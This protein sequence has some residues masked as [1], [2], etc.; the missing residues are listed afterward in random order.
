MP[1]EDMKTYRL[2]GIKLV[3]GDA[4]EHNTAPG[5]ADDSDSMHELSLRMAALRALV[6]DLLKSNQELRLALGRAKASTRQDTMHDKA[7][8]PNCPVLP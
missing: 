2:D 1:R 7:E 8:M 3:C 5:A 6:C 4:M